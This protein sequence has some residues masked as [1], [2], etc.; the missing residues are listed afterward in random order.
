VKIWIEKDARADA[1]LGSFVVDHHDIQAGV[2]QRFPEA[3]AEPIPVD[4]NPLGPNV[5]G[6]PDGLLSI[7]PRT[8]LGWD[9]DGWKIVGAFSGIEE[10]RALVGSQHR[11]P[12]R[13]LPCVRQC[14]RAH[15]MTCANQRPAVGADKQHS[16]IR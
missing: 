15:D 12:T 14:Q 1:I 8:G 16:A 2:P 13:V 11:P 7:L 6:D 9:I 3:F 10:G 4:R 5:L